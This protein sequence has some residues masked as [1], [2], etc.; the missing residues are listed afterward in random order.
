MMCDFLCLTVCMNWFAVVQSHCHYWNSVKYSRGRKHNLYAL[1]NI[2]RWVLNSCLQNY[3]AATGCISSAGSQRIT[4]LNLCPSAS[5][6]NTSQSIFNKKCICFYQSEAPSKSVVQPY[7]RLSAQQVCYQ[8]MQM[9]Q[10]Q[11]AQ[12]AASVKAAS[13]SSSPSFSGGE[14]KRI[15]H[16]PNPQ[17]ASS[18]TSTIASASH[19]YGRIQLLFFLFFPLINFFKWK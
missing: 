2:Y 9:A 10:Q 4:W 16:R 1:L 5:S 19:F 13:Q 12:L 15:A 11:A 18:K 3:L 14:R 17:I 7:K 8:R 6:I